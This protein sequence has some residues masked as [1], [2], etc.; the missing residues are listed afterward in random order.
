MARGADPLAR[1]P[2]GLHDHLFDRIRGS[3]AVELERPASGEQLEEDHAQRP[4]VRARVDGVAPGITEI[5]A[6]DP[7][8]GF[9]SLPLNLFVLGDLYR[10][11]IY[12]YDSNG[13]A[14]RAPGSRRF[15]AIGE[16]V[17]GGKR[18]VLVVQSMDI[19]AYLPVPYSPLWAC[20]LNSNRLPLK[21]PLCR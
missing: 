3:E 1:H 11:A 16:Y 5:R 14:V 10:L 18:N 13:D 17:G 21:S 15:T 4:H 2:R 7:R 19:W 20:K 12:P 8:T 6:R 9:Q